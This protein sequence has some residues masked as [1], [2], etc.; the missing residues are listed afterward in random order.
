MK[1]YIS[2]ACVVIVAF[3]ALAV[4]VSADESTFNPNFFTNVL[5]Y[6]S[7]D[8]D[9]YFSFN[10]SISVTYSLG[11]EAFYSYVDILIFCYGP[12]IKSAS[13]GTSS[14]QT[15]LTVLKVDS[16]VYR[17][18]G[19]FNAYRNTPSLTLTLNT[20]SSSTTWGQIVSFKAYNSAVDTF[21][22][23][24]FCSIR[25]RDFQDTISYIPTDEIN[26]RV[27]TT[28]QTDP[29]LQW[30]SLDIWS[31]N[32]RKYDYLEYI[33]EVSC[34]EI[35]SITAYLGDDSLPFE[36]SWI[37]SATPSN[38]TPYIFSVSVDLTGVDRTSSAKPTVFVWGKLSVATG[39][40]NH[41]DF[42][43][44]VGSVNSQTVNPVVYFLRN[45]W[46]TLKSNFTS[47]VNSLSG[48]F[49]SVI[50]TLKE[51]FS[52]SDTD[53]SGA[54]FS[55][56]AADQGDQFDDIT[57]AMQGLE[58]PEVSDS[59]IDP[60][61]IVPTSDVKFATSPLTVVLSDG[62]IKDIFMLAMIFIFAGYI[63]YGKR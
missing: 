14:S 7:A 20:G 45:I 62:V 48:W 2:V 34:S 26:R 36:V 11:F 33:L 31:D 51:G 15:N 50:D 42:L 58:K 13:C 46:T 6:A 60:G 22:E 38:G 21:N 56:E 55:T 25:S 32:W 35:T 24:A 23:T 17:C 18:Y 27:F 37:Q 53:G 40:L 12:S 9:N 19:W 52:V 54:D 61:I 63:I 49:S 3:M 47:M 57:D 5:D 41:V 8:G 16:Y 43:G 4:P 30:L 39:Q 28:E 29:S 10:N 59:D 1:R 44:C